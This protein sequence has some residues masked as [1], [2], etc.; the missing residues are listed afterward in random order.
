MVSRMRI[1]FRFVY[2]LTS[3]RQ[4]KIYHRIR[5][6]YAM[7]PN[8][9]FQSGRIKFLESVIEDLCG[10]YECYGLVYSSTRVFSKVMATKELTHRGKLLAYEL[11]YN[12]IKSLNAL[13]AHVQVGDKEMDDYR[14]YKRK[15]II[16]IDEEVDFTKLN[17]R[18]SK[19][20]WTC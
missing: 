6:F 15:M 10:M 9:E 1:G 8:S 19:T 18:G 7:E 4:I 20:T 11:L 14:E 5:T 17:L 3:S 12:K 2:K 16:A 13:D